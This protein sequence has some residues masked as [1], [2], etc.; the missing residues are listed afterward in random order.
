MKPQHT[1]G[2]IVKASC[3][4]GDPPCRRIWLEV[5]FGTTNYVQHTV[6]GLTEW[7]THKSNEV[8]LTRSEWITDQRG[9]PRKV[10]AWWVARPGFTSEGFLEFGP[11]KWNVHCVPKCGAVYTITK[12]ELIDAALRAHVAG[13]TTFALRDLRATAGAQ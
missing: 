9:T 10:G 12:D 7:T 13:Q 8:R 6:D 1:D 11:V 2:A 4:S 5:W 3:G